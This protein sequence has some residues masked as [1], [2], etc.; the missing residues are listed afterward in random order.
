MEI[1]GINAVTLAGQQLPEGSTVVAKGGNVP[2]IVAYETGSRRVVELRVDPDAGALPLSTA[3]PVLIANA[4]E[5]LAGSERNPLTLVA[6]DPLRWQVGMQE[7]QPT[8]TGPDSRVM[9]STFREGVLSFVHTQTAGTYRVRL[10]DGAQV[11]VVNAAIRGESDLAM[12]SSEPSPGGTE[13]N[14]A[15]L[16]HKDVTT[17][18]LVVALLL[19]AFEWRYRLR[20]V[21][22]G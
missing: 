14:E 5:W 9:P 17:P 21:R 20:G 4:V 15:G 6:G 3:F 1:D 7:S 22:L 11:F 18:V 2:A 8:V 16:V 13:T 12:R 19:L 10:E